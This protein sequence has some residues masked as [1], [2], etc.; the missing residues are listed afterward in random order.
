MS[1][2]LT[3]FRS[4]AR[5][6]R[7]GPGFLLIAV[8][9]LGLGIGANAAIFSVVDAVLIRPLPYPESERLVGLWGTAPGLKMDKI[10]FS[11]GAYVLFRRENR[12]LAEMA[13]YR[14]GSATLTGGQTPE[15]VGMAGVTGSLFALLRVPPA[16]GR[17]IQAADEA[18]GAEKVA[19]LADS[20]W[21][22]R[23]GGDPGA[24]G[25]T[26]RV[27]G[28]ERRIVGVMPAGFRF[29]SADAELWLPM[30]IDPARLR[31]TDFNFTAIGR[32]RPGVSPQRAAREL[33]ALVWRIPEVYGE[34]ELSRGM[35]ESAHFGVVVSALRDDVVGAVERVLWV[36]LGSV[37]C[38]LVI[39]CA[40]VANLFLVRA[41]RRQREVALR[42]TL[43]ATR[44]DVVGLFL[45]E[46]LALSLAGG[47]LGLGLAWAGVRLLVSLRPPGIPRLEE[48]GV[49]GR[50]LLFAL[51]LALA[52][53]LLCGGLAA[54]RFG[55]ALAPALR[56]GGRGGTAGR[57]T[58][59]ARNG[60]VAAQVAVALVLLVGSGLMVKS[61]WRLRNVDP[62]FEPRGVLTLRLDLP[63]AV[64]RDTPAT[65]RFV[66]QL[67][68]RVRSLPGVTAA[69]TIYPLPLAGG[70]SSSGYWIE[71][72]PLRPDQVWPQ[73]GT[74][75]VTPGAFAALGIPLLRGRIFDRLDPA[76]PSTDVVVSQALAERFWPGRNP[77]GKRL[78]VDLPGK[79]TWYTIVGV[80]GN[81]HDHSL[82]D[83]PAQS[84]YFP[85]VR[86]S[87]HEWAPRSFSLAVKG[88]INPRALVAP[89]RGVVRS[90]D[91]NLALAQVR[92]LS[93]VVER[94]M[95][96]TSFTMLLLVLAGAVALLLG[97]VGI[98]GVI[99]YVVSQRTRE[100]GV[101]MALGA[102]RVDIS[103]M[104]LREGLGITL[105]GIVIGLAGAL[106]LTRL[107]VALLYGVSPTDLPTFAAVPVMLAAVALLASWLPA[108][109][110]A[111]VEPL[112]AIRY[113]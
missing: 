76:R 73:L 96:R 103:R 67:V 37:G 106:A 46:S 70:S 22:R 39:A 84:V 71:D 113:E 12:V 95:A 6:L 1:Y 65:L 16:R 9:T 72:F 79:G 97:S 29:P 36:L 105:L 27:D 13:I 98:Y 94:S 92:P 17:T 82:E 89:V 49:D 91:P 7:R 35:I 110:A 50:V 90:L 4:L 102:R 52:A 85:M 34:E 48:I 41:E 31:P 47:L 23:F 100:I 87:E 11:D 2:L 81:V 62:G 19:V 55:F 32:L 38:I 104:V 108:R 64:Y 45:G 44:G 57:E 86:R 99:T 109:R 51:V 53:G 26:L 60:L 8:V 74:R 20:L 80:V 78:T 61:F 112:E 14:E 42:A 93:E 111:A 33:S 66:Q 21:R 63:A 24:V 68:E 28:A 83:K 58:H 54:L 5:E 101:R 77:L 18:P 25:S 88:R 40:N 59:R 3:T 75:F 15:R 56:E 69:G 10:Q 107:M 30:T 43:G